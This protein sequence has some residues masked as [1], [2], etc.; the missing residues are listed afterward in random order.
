MKRF[1]IH[2][3]LV[4]ACGAGAAPSCRLPDDAAKA[5]AAEAAAK[6]AWQAKVDAYQLCKAQ[7]KVAAQYM[8]DQSGKHGRHDGAAATPRRA[9]CGRSRGPAAAAARRGRVGHAGRRGAVARAVRRPG[10][11]RLQPARAEA[12]GD[13][14]RALAH[15]HR[16]QP[17]QRAAAVGRDGAG[18]EEPDRPAPARAEK[19]T[20][21]PR[22]C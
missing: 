14:R 15:R 3:V 19:S 21:V 6:A 8:Q 7:D 4:A 12:A 17:A 1:L 18:Q 16:R 2:R 5:K 20:G 11:I 22:P 13:F 9:G 10:A